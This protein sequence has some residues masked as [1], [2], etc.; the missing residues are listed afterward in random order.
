MLDPGLGFAKTGEHDWALLNR[1][2]E[3][4]ALG[5]PVLVGASRK[6]FLGK[7]LADEDGA[8]RP[9][10]GR[11]TATAVVSALAADRGA[12]AVRVH[13]VRSS[14]D[15]V[16]VTAAWRAGGTTGG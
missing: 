8:P 10:T 6:R 7:L 14:L 11:E 1:L 15:A 2:E 3:F 12:W 5:F 13:D 16:A 9:P 4:V